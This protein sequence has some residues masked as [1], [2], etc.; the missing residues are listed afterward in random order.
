MLNS[1]SVS[2]KCVYIYKNPFISGMITGTKFWLQLICIRRR[3]NLLLALTLDETL[4][5]EPRGA[6]GRFQTKNGKLEWVLDTRRITEYYKRLYTS[7]KFV[8][9]EAGWKLRNL[10]HSCAIPISEK[11]WLRCFFTGGSRGT[12]IHIAWLV[13]RSPPNDPTLG[14]GLYAIWP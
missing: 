12:K 7:I 13:Q 2:W 1:Q 5:A 9:A 4:W 6:A 11:N 3:T 10:W 14:V 8:I